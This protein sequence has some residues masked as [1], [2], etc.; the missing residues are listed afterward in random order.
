MEPHSKAQGTLRGYDR[1]CEIP[2][3]LRSLH[4]IFEQLAC[5]ERCVP[6]GMRLQE[7]SIRAKERQSDQGEKEGWRQAAWSE[8]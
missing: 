8:D 3:S 1:D 2:F 6:G 5:L 7:T 4:P